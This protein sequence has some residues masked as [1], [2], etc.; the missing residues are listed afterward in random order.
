MD[1]LI[2]EMKVLL[3]STFSLYLK[4]HF[5]HWNV[6]GPN[7]NEYHEFFGDF[8]E[9]VHSS[10][11]DIAEKIRILGSFAP[12]SLSRYSEMS[13]ISDQI[14]IPTDQEMFHIL[15]DDNN[16]IINKLEECYRLAE[17]NYL[18]LANYLQDRI[19]VHSKYKW[20]INSIIN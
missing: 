12:G 8:Y 19:D 14:T 15:L 4:A 3:A 11:D 5:F 6:T 7:F 10:V 18:G 9:N 2:D 16:K 17:N 13:V 20:K 1:I